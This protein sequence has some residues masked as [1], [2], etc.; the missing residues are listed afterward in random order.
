LDLLEEG[1]GASLSGAAYT[2]VITGAATS[3]IENMAS[4]KSRIAN[5][6][7]HL[8]LLTS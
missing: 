5:L 1:G 4:V 7:M 6:L 8:L 3:A 2:V